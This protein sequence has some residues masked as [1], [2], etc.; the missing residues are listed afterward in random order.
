MITIKFKSGESRRINPTPHFFID[1]E[2]QKLSPSEINKNIKTIIDDI[3]GVNNCYECYYTI[4]DKRI[5]II[6]NTEDFNPFKELSETELET[7]QSNKKKSIERLKILKLDLKK[8]NFKFTQRILFSAS[9]ISTIS[10]VDIA[11]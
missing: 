2:G 9:G 11:A 3:G 7:I 6:K 8:S 1:K 4:G 5:D 10:L